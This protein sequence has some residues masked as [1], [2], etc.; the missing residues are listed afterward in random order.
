MR[1][2]IVVM[3]SIALLMGGCG[4]PTPPSPIPPHEPEPASAPHLPPAQS[5]SPLSP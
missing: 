3:S 1:Q 2:P 4:S 5:A